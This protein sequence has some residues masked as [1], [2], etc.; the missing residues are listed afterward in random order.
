MRKTSVIPVLTIC[1]IITAWLITYSGPGMMAR[2]DCLGSGDTRLWVLNPSYE[3]AECSCENRVIQFDYN[4]N[5]LSDTPWPAE[6][7]GS[8]W[9]HV[10]HG[11]AFDHFKCRFWSYDEE[12]GLVYTVS[13]TGGQEVYCSFENGEDDFEDEAVVGLAYDYMNNALWIRSQKQQY[14]GGDMQ[15]RLTRYAVDETPAGISLKKEFEVDP[16]SFTS[17]EFDEEDGWTDL[18]SIAVDPVTGDIWLPVDENNDSYAKPEGSRP[19]LVRVSSE[20][21]VLTVIRGEK[22]VSSWDIDVMGRCIWVGLGFYSDAYAGDDKPYLYQFSIQCIPEGELELEELAKYKIGPET[23]VEFPEAISDV[24]VSPGDNAVWV[25]GA[26]FSEGR[27]YRFNMN[28][29]LTFSADLADLVGGPINTCYGDQ[30]CPFADIHDYIV[31]DKSNGSCYLVLPAN[32]GDSDTM[33]LRHISPSGNVIGNKI[34]YDFPCQSIYGRGVLLFADRPVFPDPG[35]CPSPTKVEVWTDKLQY[36]V[37]EKVTA[38]CQATNECVGIFWMSIY[39]SGPS[40]VPGFPYGF[41]NQYAP[42]KKKS[43]DLGDSLLPGEYKITAKVT[44]YSCEVTTAEYWFAVKEKAIPPVVNIITDL[45]TYFPGQAIYFTINASAK[46]EIDWIKW[47]LVPETG[48][49]GAWIEVEGTE[50]AQKYF[51]GIHYYL[52]TLTLS[53]ILPAGSYCLE[54]KV[55]APGFPSKTAL[56]KKFEVVAPD[57][58]DKEPK[59]WIS[60]I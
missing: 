57:F 41:P 8:L 55:K 53:T 38:H 14:P 7:S 23:G 28:G 25:V 58:K 60:A 51:L 59:V 48:L 13:S 16:G 6:S 40:S 12:A 2:A 11:A 39:I 15:G 47:R 18:K 45:D 32:L 36:E 43:M 31:A 20:G 21:E 35:N 5:I 19:V 22:Y 37:G 54:A 30:F 3:S 4:L 33:L 34:E 44:T 50:E 1:L 10:E 9:S 56:S 49:A 27:L 24:S 46:P 29:E 42:D 26:D 17:L 52:K